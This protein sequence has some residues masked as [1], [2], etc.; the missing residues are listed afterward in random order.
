MLMQSQISENLVADEGTLG[1]L[2]NPSQSAV[3]ILE[4]TQATNQ[5][6]ALQAKQSIDAA[7]LKLAQDRAIAA[8]QARS[9]RGRTR[10]RGP[11]P[12]LGRR[13][14]LFAGDRPRLPRL[15]GII[16]L[17]QLIRLCV[18]AVIGVGAAFLIPQTHAADTVDSLA[19]DPQRLREVQR[20]CSQDWAGTRDALCTAAS[21]ARRKR[22][23]GS[24]R[25]RYRPHPVE[26]FPSLDEDGKPKANAVETDE[27]TTPDKPDAE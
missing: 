20:R 2:V 1:D 24:G 5:L 18:V 12:L 7:R 11:P 19:A 23:M 3:G 21:K 9:R 16:M 4:A 14:Q 6:L 26:I 13:R 22:F 15:T 25:P 10:T 27:L 17:G 8:E